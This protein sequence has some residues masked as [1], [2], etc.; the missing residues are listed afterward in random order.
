MFFF[1]NRRE[2]IVIVAGFETNITGNHSFVQD[3][4]VITLTVLL[5][6]VCLFSSFL[7]LQSYDSIGAWEKEEKEG[8]SQERHIQR[9]ERTTWSGG[10]NEG[11][12]NKI[13]KMANPEKCP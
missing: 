4:S 5:Y 8:T 6:L 7:D 10:V 13:N 3:S 11:K 2:D 9:I 12:K 1:S